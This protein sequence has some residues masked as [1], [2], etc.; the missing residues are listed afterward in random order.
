[1]FFLYIEKH[2]SLQQ[3]WRCSCKI[4]SRRIGSSFKLHSRKL[5]IRSN[6]PLPM[7]VKRYIP[8]Y[9]ANFIS[10]LNIP[11][12]WICAYVYPYNAITHR[13]LCI[14]KKSDYADI[15]GTYWCCIHVLILAYNKWHICQN[16]V[17]SYGLRKTVKVLATKIYLRMCSRYIYIYEM[18]KKLWKNTHMLSLWHI[19]NW[20]SGTEAQY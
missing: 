12:G 16:H 7:Y 9:F 6:E 13:K 17:T 8:T 19:F 2:S 1:M 15:I 5:C 11:N 14:H 10:Y 20:T 3:R 4:R 18:R